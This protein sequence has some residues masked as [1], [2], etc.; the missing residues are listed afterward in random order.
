MCFGLTS[1]YAPNQ[2]YAGC[3]LFCLACFSL[4]NTRSSP[5]DQCTVPMSR[6]ITRYP[7][8][9][10]RP[11]GLTRADTEILPT[12]IPCF[13]SWLFGM[14]LLTTI[15]VWYEPAGIYNYSSLNCILDLKLWMREVEALA[16]VIVD[17]VQRRSSI[18]HNEAMRS[19]WRQAV[20]ESLCLF[21]QCP[22]LRSALEEMSFEPVLVLNS[23]LLYTVLLLYHQES[24][25]RPCWYLR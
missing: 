16:D 5:G 2:S 4:I 11:S 13:F 6:S 7:R 21:S 1:T 15:L 8:L 10:E 3:C 18:K 20:Q 23:Y 24:A 17:Y 19:V 12:N 22:V 25:T 14:D 9:E